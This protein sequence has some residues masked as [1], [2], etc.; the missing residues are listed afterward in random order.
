VGFLAAGLALASHRP[1]LDDA[2]YVNIAVG[3]ADSPRDPILRNC[4]L[5]DLPD[6]PLAFHPYRFHSV[7]LLGGALSYVTGLPAI[8]FFHFILAGLAA[9][10]S[11]LAYGR[12][13]SLTEKR[14]AALAVI[15]VL[16]VLLFLGASHRSYGNFGLVRLFQGKAVYATAV[17]PLI[18]LA[19]LRFSSRPSWAGWSLLLAAQVCGLGMTSSSLF[20]TPLLMAIAL[21]AGCGSLNKKSLLV[22]A[23]G[24]ASLFYLGVVTLY[25]WLENLARPFIGRPPS[26]LKETDPLAYLGGNISTVFGRG[27]L[28]LIALGVFLLAWLFFPAGLGRRLALAAPLVFL[29]TILNPWLVPLFAKVEPLEF[30][31]FF[32]ALPFPFFIVGILLSPFRL[33]GRLPGWA[34]YAAS[35]VFLALFLWMG[36]SFVLRPANGVR[37]GS[38]SLKVDAYYDLAFRLARSVPRHSLILAPDQVNI[39]LGTIQPHVFALRVRGYEFQGIKA[40]Y[41][42]EE[43][44]W[45]EFMVSYVDGL[46][47]KPEDGDLFRQGLRRFRLAAVCLPHGLDWRVEATGL[48]RENGFAPSR[49]FRR[50]DIW[51]RNAPLLPSVPRD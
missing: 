39:W 25:L 41:G 40:A 27:R 34:L 50:H 23:A 12:L 30:W 8:V 13:F 3:A 29:L 32:W 2:Y 31:R 1:D 20:S 38:P 10:L 51:V 15:L 43:V 47:H 48:L 14:Q 26:V 18:L 22:L 4:A 21:L 44:W 45:R 46:S 17:V 36:G 7:E 16:V 9:L 49:T 33:R 24:L 42:S 19:A 28:L 5:Y 6:I 37:M 11:I 35:A